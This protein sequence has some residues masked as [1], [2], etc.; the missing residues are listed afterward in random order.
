MS[1]TPG[2]AAAPLHAILDAARWA[3]SGDNAQTWRFEAVGPDEVVVHLATEAGANV[4][5]YRGGEP[6][7][8][9]GGM[10]LQ[11]LRI[12]ATAQGR[13][14]EW[15]LEHAGERPG[16]P[17]P[18]SPRPDPGATTLRSHLDLY[19]IRVRFPP[20]PGLAP[21]PLL[22]TLPLRSV[23]RRP[24]RLRRLERRE[25]AALEAALGPDVRV[26]WHEGLVARRRFAGLGQRATDIRLRIREAFQVHQRVIDWTR[27]DSPTGIPAQAVGLD[28]LTLRTMRWAMQSWD[29]MN[30]LN[31]LTGTM[32]AAMQLDLGPGLRCAGFF[33]LRPTVPIGEADR[34]A[35]LL[36]AGEA[37]QR[38]WLT[39]TALG[40]ALQ[41]NLATLIFAHYGQAGLPFTEDAA[42]RAKAARLA[43]AFRD[44]TG[45]EP[46]SMVFL[47]R[48]GEPHR[49][50][51]AARSGRRS[52]AE[53]MTTSLHGAATSPER[54]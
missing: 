30:G 27:R 5:E 47:G 21:D 49:R 35:R 50:P 15:T 34:P 8:L 44:V 36:R 54:S 6:S 37:I 12:A 1:A 17:S 45:A 16:D 31:R 48:I 51:S 2:T 43:Q 46:D 23:D 19:R 41:P 4:Y 32:A 40:L 33:C 24:Y 26:D 18:A 38:F 28:P 25:R 11:S 42:V 39:A 7:L 9:S 53:L 22:P 10:L 20:R 3:P 29:R 13:D 52:M 14:T